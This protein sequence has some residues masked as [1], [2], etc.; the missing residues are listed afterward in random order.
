MRK[1]ISALFITI[2]GVVESPD[3]WSF[4]HFDEGMMESLQT[5][6]AAQDTVLMGRVT[7][8]QWASYWPTSNDEP[9]ASYINQTPK[10]VVSTTLDKV[11]WKNSH[12]IKGDV[13]SEVNKLKQQPGK[14]IGTA[15]SPT[16]VQ[17]L[18]QND[19]ADELILT[20][21]P[22]IAGNGKKLFN[23]DSDLKRMKLVSSKATPTGVAIL[24]YQRYQA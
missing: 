19:L 8:D 6:L 7:Y 15:G 3:K 21:Y 11:D 17:W 18:V 10:Y 13:A 16:L 1:L 14:N 9:F 5:Q 2:D 4:D 20:V 23:K 24:T 22:V 12:L